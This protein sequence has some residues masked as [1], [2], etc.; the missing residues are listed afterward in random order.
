MFPFSKWLPRAVSSG[1]PYCDCPDC[2]AKDGPDECPI[3]NGVGWVENDVGEVECTECSGSGQ[4]ESERY[5]AL[6]R[7]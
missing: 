3:C 1:A 2:N 4:V 5:R 7:R 6:T